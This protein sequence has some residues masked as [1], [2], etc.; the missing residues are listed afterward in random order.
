MDW[1]EAAGFINEEPQQATTTVQIGG[2]DKNKS[3]AAVSVSQICKLTRPNEGLVIHGK[4]IYHIN[5]VAF[6]YEILDVSPQKVHL[7]VDD[8]SGGGPLEVSHIFGDTSEED[9]QAMNIKPGDY[10]RCIGVAKFSQDKANVIAYNLK[11]I[12]DI[13]EI[14]LHILEVIRDSL[15]YAGHTAG[16]KQEAPKPQPVSA[17]GGFGKLSTRDK[18]LVQFL[19]TKGGDQGLHIDDIAKSF[20]AFTKS[21]ILESLSTLSNEGICWQSD[22]E[23]VWCV[24]PS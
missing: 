8:H 19:K 10:I 18:H 3:I 13:N 21:E 12:E 24:D 5:L 16:A 4:K 17:E 2:D 14:S 15:F 20:T 1:G 7:M 11:V 9:D 22:D 6:V 23:N